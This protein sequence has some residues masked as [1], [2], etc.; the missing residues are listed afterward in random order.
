MFWSNKGVF[1]NLTWKWD[2]LKIS[3]LLNRSFF[4]YKR[5]CPST[6]PPLPC[7]PS[8]FPRKKKRKKEKHFATQI[9]RCFLYTAGVDIA[10]FWL[11]L[12]HKFDLVMIAFVSYKCSLGTSN[13]FSFKCPCLSNTYWAIALNESRCFV[14]TIFDSNS[15]RRSFINS[16]LSNFLQFLYL[17]TLGFCFW[18]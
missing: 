6:P 17:L 2:N 15:F 5:G 16:F 1:E 14:W 10:L 13:I 9:F 18:K 7:P 8:P 11:N 12:Y 3:S 4:S